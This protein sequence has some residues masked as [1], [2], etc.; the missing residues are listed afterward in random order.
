[1]YRNREDAGPRIQGE[2]EVD[3]D[4]RDVHGALTEHEVVTA[5]VL[6]IRRQTLHL[7]DPADSAEHAFGDD[8]AAHDF[9]SAG[10]ARR[11]DDAVERLTRP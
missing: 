6:G 9:S 10:P 1:L 7:D 3:V 4:H 2:L 5:D 8:D 11:D